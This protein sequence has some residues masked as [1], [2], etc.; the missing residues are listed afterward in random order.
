VGIP[1]DRDD[2]TA[3]DNVR[4]A[5]S[6]AGKALKATH[7]GS[8]KFRAYVA[9]HGYTQNGAPM[10]WYVDDPTTTPAERLR[11]EVYWPIK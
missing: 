7:V 1:V 5:Q 8:E 6:Y 3:A 4:L 11:T 10:S 9:A 2:V